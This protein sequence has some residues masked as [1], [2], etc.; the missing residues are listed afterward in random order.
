M[1][2][3]R[4]IRVA[5]STVII[6]SALLS[7]ALVGGL[8]LVCQPRH[9]LDGLF[10]LGVAA[11]ILGAICLRSVELHPGRL[12]YRGPWPRREVDL[13]GVDAVRVDGGPPPRMHLY[14]ASSERPLLAFAIKPFTR[15]DLSAI[16]RHIEAA[17][18]AVELDERARHMRA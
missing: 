8:V 11:V 10:G 12:V 15:E 17:R 4:V 14:A 1:D 6:F 3:P 7:P 2:S 5:R 13:T 18:P 16:V 9:F